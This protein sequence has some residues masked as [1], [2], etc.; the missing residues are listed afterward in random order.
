MQT[1]RRSLLAII[2]LTLTLVSSIQTTSWSRFLHKPTCEAHRFAAEVVINAQTL[3]DLI[4]SIAV[5]AAKTAA[6]A[7]DAAADKTVEAAKTAAATAASTA[8]AVATVIGHE[9]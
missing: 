5:L 8:A 6:T 7:A 4:D 9:S 1:Q 2:L 3:A